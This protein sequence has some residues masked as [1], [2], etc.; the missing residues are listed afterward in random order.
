MPSIY[1]CIAIISSD[2]ARTSL[3]PLFIAKEIFQVK[4]TG[5]NSF[6]L[7]SSLADNILFRNII[8]IDYNVSWDF[9]NSLLFC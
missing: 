3:L 8:G 4:K 5:L 1:R 9:K 7:A 2:D 6:H